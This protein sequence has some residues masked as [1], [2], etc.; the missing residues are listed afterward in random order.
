MTRCDLRTA[1]RRQVVPP[2]PMTR[3]AIGRIGAV[4]GHRHHDLGVAPHG[5]GDDAVDGVVFGPQNT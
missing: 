5:A 2:G 1:R 4:A 3:D